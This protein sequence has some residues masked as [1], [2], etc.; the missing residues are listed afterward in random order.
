MKD[1]SVLNLPSYSSH[2][3]EN[4]NGQ[5]N[6]ISE[7]NSS[8]RTNNRSEMGFS[9]QEGSKN[10]EGTKKKINKEQGQNGIK[11]QGHWTNQEHQIYVE[12]L[13]QHHCTSMQSQQNRKN[14]KIFKLMS[15][16]IGTRS[17]SQCRSHHQ[18]F[19]P[20]TAAGQKRNKRN[21]RRLS[22]QNVEGENFHNMT[23]KPMIQFNTPTVKPILDQCYDECDGYIS[24]YEDSRPQLQNY[25]GNSNF[26]YKYGNRW[27][28][29]SDLY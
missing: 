16:T 8:Q 3:Q 22:N 26:D 14:N 19:N 12:F 5:Q 7:T 29:D 20:Y 17:P 10:T 18:K 24:N 25:C 28:C 1:S 27:D 15:Q 4:Q 2:P 21:R 13:E 23:T 11:N 9:Q 6:E